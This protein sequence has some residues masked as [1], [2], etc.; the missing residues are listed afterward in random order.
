VIEKEDRMEIYVCDLCGEK[1][2]KIEK[3]ES[4]FR[5]LKEGVR[6]SLPRLTKFENGAPAVDLKSHDLCAKCVS[7]LMRWLDEKRARIS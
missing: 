4:L 3:R 7:D 5:P 2:E 6:M 1:I